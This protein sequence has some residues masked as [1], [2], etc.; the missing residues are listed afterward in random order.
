[1]K[2]R[3]G[4]AVLMLVCGISVA[5]A[6]TNSTK[7]YTNGWD[8]DSGYNKLYSKATEVTFSGSV[9]GLVD[10]P[11][12]TSMGSATTILVKSKNGGTSTVDLGPTWFI[13]HQNMKIGL[14]DEV[15]V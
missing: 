7:S 12:L 8:A 13:Q 2:L 4:L 14:K 5:T 10:S 1:M 15:T 11:P 3:Y 9:V 6:Q